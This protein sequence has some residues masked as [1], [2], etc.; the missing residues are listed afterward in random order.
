MAK[1]TAAAQ[2]AEYDEALLDCRDIRHAWDRL[3]QPYRSG[4]EIHSQLVC[5]R[6]GTVRTRV[7]RSKAKKVSNLY[8]NR[9]KGYR[10]K[11]GATAY[12]VRKEILRRFTVFDSEDAMYLAV[13][14]K[15]ASK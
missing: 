13:F 9:P 11:G 2:L 4:T 12:D 14:N 3:G 15:G 7:W 8:A 1:V 6:C 5:S 10:I